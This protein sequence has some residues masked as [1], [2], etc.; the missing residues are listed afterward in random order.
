MRKFLFSF[1]LVSFFAATAAFAQ[2]RIV[3]GKVTSADDGLPLPG[4]TVKI[5]ST[6]TGVVSAA[7]G[8]FAIKVTT[9]DVL[10]LSFI[11]F[12]PAEIKV[13]SN[14]NDYSVKLSTDT[15]LLNE[16]VVTDGY[17][18]QSKKSYTG[19]ATT[20][21]GK[22][23]ENK[24]FATTMQSLQ[25][26][27]AGLN[28]SNNSG[29]PGADVEVNL[30]G[31]GSIGASSQPLYVVDN[32]IIT[33]GD[34][35]VQT[36]TANVLAGLNND[37]IASI[38]VLKDASATA[39]YGSRGSNGVI[40]ITTRKGKAGKTVVEADAELGTTANLPVP[41][42]GKPLTGPEYRTLAIEGLKNYGVSQGTLDYYNQLYKGNGNNWYDLVTNNG[43]QEQYN[44]S[45][46]GGDE[47]TKVYS[48]IGYFKQDATTLA[49]SLTRITGLLNIDHKIS[50]T[51]TLSENINVSNVNQYT[52][53][54][55]GFYSNP[56]ASAYFLTPY[57]PAYNANGTFDI[58]AKDYP[59]GVSNYNPLYIAAHDKNYLSQTR[60]LSNT[61]LTWNI[62]ST[63][64]FT[65]FV[66]LDDNILEETVYNN[67]KHGDGV[68]TQ[69]GSTDTYTRPF[70]YLVRNQFDYRYNIS[71]DNDDFYVDMT[72]G[73]E[74]QKSQ[75]YLI[76][77]YA[78]GF[79]LTQPSLTATGNGA[80]PK[81]ASAYNDV[82]SYDSFYARGSINYKDLYSLSASFRRDGS[83]V[84][85][86]NKA[87]GNFYSVGGAWNIDGEGFFTNQHIFSSAKIRSSYGL[88]G[89]ASGLLYYGAL[90]TAGYG[91]NY[92]GGGNGQNFS[93]IGN[94]D[95]TWET[96]HK[97]DAGADFGFLHDRLTFSVDYYHDNISGLIESVPLSYT[98]GFSTIT[99]NVGAMLNR[100][101]EIEV[102]GV[103]IKLKDFSWTTSFNIALN[104][105]TVT[106][107]Y[108]N[109]SFDNPNYNFQTA[110]GKDLYTWYAPQF[111]G[112]DPANGNV[113][114]Y[115][116]ATKTKKTTNYE[117][118]ARVD[119][120][121]ADPKA[122]G[123]F[124]NTFTYKGFTL[125]A[126]LYYNIGNYIN[127]SWANYFSDGTYALSSNQYQYV[128]NNRWTTPGQV[129][130]VPKYVYGGTNNG[131]ASNFSSRFLYKGDYIRLKNLTFGY[132]FKNLALLKSLGVSKLYLYARGT[133]LFTKTYDNRLPFDPEVGLEGT[134][135]LEVPQVRTFTVGLNVGF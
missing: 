69:G 2:T 9:G 86:R 80:V 92:G 87:Y 126:D 93:T 21:N 118:A 30:R 62:I 122:F 78:T 68:E 47:K 135:N 119:A 99:A 82:D 133:N 84:F 49:S 101:F 127:D 91:N 70:N 27:V 32:M 40:V 15:R 77:A 117:D 81:T 72:A 46:S 120:M 125:S 88:T 115:T 31:V 71:K 128:Y 12:T 57:Q 34:Q 24:P 123:G 56:I 1:C 63:L 105:N 94:P 39:I 74:A 54:N 29:Q 97:F 67:P 16:V 7:D 51:I 55:G 13:V 14:V 103:P 107:L 42:A 43:S 95:L 98:S 132:D 109:Q 60:L 124:T 130:D 20:V 28:I 5:K 134:S 131:E 11:G 19:A 102:T 50:N 58:S 25:G 17:A 53:T 36:T 41:E 110:V 89:N 113:E 106:E 76:N 37:D 96:A 66:G 90:P 111:A 64:K 65:S 104:R 108:G 61:T 79:P 85:G 44:V 45:V 59:D 23:N 73:Y 48:S 33:S 100:G 3:T 116:D 52:P 129:T 4:V 112:I 83:S 114:W 8:E 18:V 75:T 6:G 121:Q 35:S 26:E 10:D 38:T 22:Q